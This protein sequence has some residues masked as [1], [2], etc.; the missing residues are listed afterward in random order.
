M[1]YDDR[2]CGLGEGPLWHPVLHE[3]FWFDINACTLHSK[4]KSWSFDLSVSAAGW[5]DENTLLIASESGLHRFDINSGVLK[6]AFVHI[7]ANTPT[8][9]SN[10]GRADPWGGFWLGTMGFQAQ[11]KAGAIYRYYKGELRKLVSDVTISN[12]ICF[13]PNRSHAHYTDTPT[14][15]IMRV[16]LDPA[17]GW[18]IEDAKVWL[19][20]NDANLSPDGAVIDADGTFWVALWGAGRVNGYAPVG[21]L[22]ASHKID[23]LHTTCPA[24]GGDHLGDMFITSATQGIAGKLKNNGKT[25]RLPKIGKGQKEHQVIL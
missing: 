17:S 24:F 19:D 2:A 18:P 25:F 11:A 9:R 8:T 14:K 23:G 4:A 15:Q 21:T 20:L 13:T 6:D 1:I 22:I 3:L 5:I 10:D 16:A 7:E 12:A